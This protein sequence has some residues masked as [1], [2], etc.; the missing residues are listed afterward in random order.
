MKEG[1][2][3]DQGLVLLLSWMA[4]RDVR[5]RRLSVLLAEDYM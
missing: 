4:V 1:L 5:E 3:T 2:V